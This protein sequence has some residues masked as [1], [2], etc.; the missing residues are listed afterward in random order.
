MSKAP[1]LSLP[2]SPSPSTPDLT[3]SHDPSPL[4]AT[5]VPTSNA[6]SVPS[7][8]TSGPIDFI[9]PVLPSP[10]RLHKRRPPVVPLTPDEEAAAAR[11]SSR[12][13]IAGLVIATTIPSEKKNPLQSRRA[14]D[15]R[16]HLRT[17]PRC[18]DTVPGCRRCGGSFAPL[19][20]ISASA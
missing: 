9:P 12:Y 15:C 8:S 7:A 10:S 6:Q 2:Q 14:L 5:P 20:R 4:S 11:V 19:S 1:L 17:L 18:R 16:S 13:V 3:Q